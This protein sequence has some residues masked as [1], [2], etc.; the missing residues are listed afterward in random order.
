MISRR[1]TLGRIV[2]KNALIF[3]VGTLASSAL[4]LASGPAFASGLIV[5]VVAF[6][7][8]W[9]VSL[10]L[11]DASV[12]DIFWGIGFVAIGWYYVATV[13]ETAT[14]RGWL[15]C[16][17]VTV[18]GVRLALHIG[19]RNAGAGEDFRYQRWR[20][21]AGSN[22]WWISYFKV[23]LLQAILLWIVSSPLLLAQSGDAL[24]GWTALDIVSLLL[25]LAGFGFEAVADWQ[26][27][28]FKREPTNEGQIMRSGLWSLSRHPNYF[29]EAL[30]WWGIGL[31]AYPVG[32]WL[33]FLGP[34]M[35][36]FLLIKVSGAAML[37]A[38]LVE[39]RPGYAEYIRT[40]RS[41]LPLPLTLKRPRHTSKA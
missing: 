21:Q 20:Q 4:L 39:R 23:F 2:D 31:L 33:S 34:L 13:S 29:G 38:A 8:L 26:L 36:T 15:A 32:G 41:F 35:I 27:M 37:D 19:F 11:K 25:W 1:R 30:L 10:A 16:S 18:W 9:L 12:V 40:T 7:L 24:G 3:A 28:R 22:F 14:T 5:I 17:L 6:S